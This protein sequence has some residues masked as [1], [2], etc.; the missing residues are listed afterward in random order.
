MLNKKQ[1]DELYFILKEDFGLNLK[2]EEL[3]ELAES[4]T[5]YFGLLE[6]L[7]KVAVLNKNVKDS[8]MT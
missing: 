5:G 3:V 4:L 1:L 2:G 8:L 6:D 7:H